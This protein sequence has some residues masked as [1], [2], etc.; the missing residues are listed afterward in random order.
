MKVLH[1]TAGMLT[2][3]HHMIL[4]QQLNEF[5]P[6]LSKHTR[7]MASHCTGSQTLLR[8]KGQWK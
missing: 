4:F 6:T 3:I 1:I 8:L 5:L 7:T 2:S